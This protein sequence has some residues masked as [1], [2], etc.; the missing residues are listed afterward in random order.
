MNTFT[1]S[2]PEHPLLLEKKTELLSLRIGPALTGHLKACSASEGLAVNQVVTKALAFYVQP[3]QPIHPPTTLSE[4]V[5]AEAEAYKAFD[6]D[7]V[8]Q[9]IRSVATCIE[10]GSI[11]CTAQSI[12]DHF[13]SFCPPL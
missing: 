2:V 13:L 3:F 1:A 5:A 10:D 12:L 7:S 8:I 4:P 6:N 9:A 11:E